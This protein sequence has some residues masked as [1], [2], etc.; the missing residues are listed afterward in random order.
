[1]EFN[2]EFLLIPNTPFGDLQVRYYGIIIVAAM[3]IAATVAAGLA[4]RD[5]RDSDHIWGGLT[6]AI[7]PGII[8][9]RLWFVLFPP[10]SLTAGCGMESGVCMDT[11][12]FLQNF[13]NLENGA[14]AIWSGG[15]SIFGAVLGG[16]LGAW[17]YLSRWHN[18]VARI[19]HYIFLPIG[20]VFAAIEWLFTVIVQT[21]RGQE[22]TPFAIPKFEPEFPDEGMPIA[23]WLDIAA[24]ALP[25]A[26][27]IGRIAN[28]VN[29]ELYGPP[30]GVQWWGIPIDAAN[31]VGE[32]ADR[33]TYPTENPVTLFHPLFLYEMVWNI[34]AFF[35]LR[36]LFL[37]QRDKFLKGDFFLLYVAQYAF[38]RFWLEFLR[39]EV[40]YI[41]GTEI[42]SSQVFTAIVFVL[43]LVFFFYRR[44][45]GVPSATENNDAAVAS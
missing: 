40:A 31:R 35:V 20:I 8:F 5:K 45:N 24:V 7:F 21:V 43:A 22:R 16:L 34:A 32:F 19:F 28:Y 12:W 42:N 13:F 2:A 17:L 26:Q 44:R 29:Q 38:A 41:P 4:R 3:M 39:I 30:T 10:V 23:P 9:A 6:W 1:M 18:P 14:V 37:Q 27:A 33:V 15:L 11:A 36:R 25:L